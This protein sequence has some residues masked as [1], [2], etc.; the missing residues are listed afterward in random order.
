MQN[1]WNL[2]LACKQ[3]QLYG[4]VNFR[5]FPE[6][7]PRSAGFALKEFRVSGIRCTLRWSTSVV[8]FWFQF[9]L[10][11]SSVFAERF[12]W[13]SRIYQRESNKFSWLYCK[14]NNLKSHKF[15]FISSP[16]FQRLFAL[17]FTLRLHN[18]EQTL[19]TVANLSI[20]SS[21]A[22]NDARPISCSTNQEKIKEALIKNEI[23]QDDFFP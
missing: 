18:W 11:Y 14:E 12:Q 19:L 20:H 17:V 15:H 4:P 22:P 7:G 16:R 10:V 6:I 2:Y 13:N 5:G 8:I 9:W 1:Y 21:G 23:F 3:Q